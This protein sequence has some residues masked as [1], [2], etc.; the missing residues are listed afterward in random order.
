[1]IRR[2]SSAPF[3]LGASL[4]LV[5]LG[6]WAQV[7]PDPAAR[8]STRDISPADQARDT[9]NRYAECI[10]KTRPAAVR[11]ALSR[12][13]AV[14]PVE[15]AKIADGDCLMNG[16]LR[17]N[18]SL[19]RGAIFRAIYMRDFSHE[20]LPSAW[21][22]AAMTASANPLLTF[23]DCVVQL[24]PN[25]AR[26]FVLAKPATPDERDAVANLSATLGRCV[27]P[28]DQVGFSKTVLQGALAEALYRRTEAS[29]VA[30]EAA[31]VN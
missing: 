2:A 27:A 31:E 12:P 16:E 7:L 29:A 22:E 5:P 4:A 1:M 13:D 30:A 8:L 6:A 11:R 18:A 25:N 28:G 19:F 24:D 20:P 15:L 10:M 14:I 23:A 9:M 21:G 17:M 26:S 3:L